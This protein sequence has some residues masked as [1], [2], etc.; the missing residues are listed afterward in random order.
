MEA[1]LIPQPVPEDSSDATRNATEL[2]RYSAW[3]HAGLGAAECEQAETGECADPDHFHAWC[4][5]PNQLQHESIRERALGA[6]A[7]R[8]RQ[9]H[10][11]ETDTYAVLE[12]DMD[13]LARVAEPAA[14][15]EELLNREWWKR[16]LEAV[17]DVEEVAEY[18]TIPHDRER[19]DELRAMDP[20]KVPTD[21]R[22]ELERHIER[23]TR[24]VSARRAELDAPVRAA[25]EA[26]SPAELIDQIR[27]ERINSE[28]GAAFMETYSRWEWVAGT[29]TTNR[30]TRQRAFRDIEQLIDAA[31]EVLDAIAAAFTDLESSLQQRGAA[32]N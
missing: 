7:R 4:R 15:V 23:F 8:L 28:A 12:S 18:K 30:P 20:D 17:R 1:A 3:V 26:L 31:P 11:P 24:A 25:L 6:K 29:F 32:G 19:L 27:T 16:Q 2:F 22:D 9:L 5:L 14:L 21:E 13:E 10:D